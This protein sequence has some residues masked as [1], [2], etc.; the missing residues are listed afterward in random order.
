MSKMQVSNVCDM[1]GS[2]LFLYTFK[3]PSKVKPTFD[4]WRE[5]PFK[6]Q[7]CLFYYLNIFFQT[8]APN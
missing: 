8:L 4:L 2:N 1:N 7:T 3:T 5:I 6:F